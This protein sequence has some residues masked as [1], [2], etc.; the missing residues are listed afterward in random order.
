MPL[1]IWGPLDDAL[2]PSCLTLGG[3][4]THDFLPPVSTELWRPPGSDPP[5][6]VRFFPAD[7]PRCQLVAGRKVAP[8]HVGVDRSPSQAGSFADFLETQ[9]TLLTHDWASTGGDRGM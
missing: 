3:R 8:R 1:S 9:V 4:Q 5:L 7:P 6:D 2:E